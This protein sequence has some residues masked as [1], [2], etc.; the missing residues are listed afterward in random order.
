MKYC[1]QT[2]PKLAFW[3]TEY[4]LHRG[5]V[6]MANLATLQ[7]MSPALKEV[8]AS[9]DMIGWCEFLRGKVSNQIRMIQD[10]H[11]IDTGASINCSNWMAQFVRRLVE[12]SHAQWLYQ[13]LILHH[14]AKGYRCKQ[15]ESAIRRK[16]KLLADKRPIDLPQEC[17]YLL[18]LPQRPS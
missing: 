16:V 8:A 13:N 7:P 6:H 10:A 5:Q 1:N 2:Q 14:Y 11:C 9:K 18:E 3:I 15:T 12:A 4:L 17:L